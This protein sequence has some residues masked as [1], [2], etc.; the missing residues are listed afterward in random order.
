MLNNNLLALDVGSVR[1]GV[2][3]CVRDVVIARPLITLNRQDNDFWQ[4]LIKLI[5]DHSIGALVVG[6]PRGLDGQETDQTRSVRGFA[7]ELAEHTALPQHWQD[8]ALTSVKAE[9]AL[10]QRGGAYQKSDIDALAAS[11][12]LSDYLQEQGVVA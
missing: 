12:I 2:A 11:Y 8:E 7:L 10:R 6:L 1:V 9:E 3:I 5:A 4:Q